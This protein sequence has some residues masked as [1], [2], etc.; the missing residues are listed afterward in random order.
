M[1]FEVLPKLFVSDVEAARNESLLG[2]HNISSILSVMTEPI[3]FLDFKKIRHHK[4]LHVDDIESSDLLSHFPSAND[5][6]D[7]GRAEGGVLVHCHAGESR[8]V[9]VVMAYIMKTESINCPSA[10]RRIKTI[11]PSAFPNEG[12]REQLKLY[13]EMKC[14]LDDSNPQY[15][16][17]K[18]KMM[19]ESRHEGTGAI[20]PSSL[21]ADPMGL[22]PSQ[23]EPVF[24]CRACRRR[25]I[26]AE[27][28]LE[29]DHGS[30]Q[31]SF[32]ASKRDRSYV[33]GGRQ[34]ACSSFF[35][36]PMVWMKGVSE[37]EPEG[38]LLCP[39]CEARLGYYNWA[40]AQCSCGA[41]ITPSFQI[42]KNRLDII[43]VA[44]K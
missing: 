7:R 2:Q 24:R 31:Y 11:V 23:D 26:R 43:S 38:K 37:G 35:V 10:F 4:Q 29:H 27:N 34:D 6:I 41:W 25:I 44:P 17:L 9:A 21:A 22:T 8:S 30:G 33:P 16:L 40:G 19:T 1:L 39:K 28:I 32:S 36:E 42:H 15:K 13:F 12:F 18:L 14:S 20:E 3:S 5:F